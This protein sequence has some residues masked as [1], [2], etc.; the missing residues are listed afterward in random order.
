[1]NKFHE[2]IEVKVLEESPLEREEQPTGPVPLEGRLEED[3]V[4]ADEVLQEVEVGAVTVRL[5]KASHIDPRSQ[6]C[7]FPEAVPQRLSVPN[8]HPPDIKRKKLD[9]HF[10]AL[11]VLMSV[12]T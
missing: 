6:L 10:R 2:I 1:M 11:T 9:I 3:S 5:L 7:N 4:V 12:W 8:K